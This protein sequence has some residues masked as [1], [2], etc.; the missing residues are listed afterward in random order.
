MY[1]VA[2]ISKAVIVWESEDRH[3]V[4]VKKRK[5]D[6][7]PNDEAI[8]QRIHHYFESKQISELGII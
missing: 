6:C 4:D 3:F 5:L 8:S 1:F 2:N 7:R